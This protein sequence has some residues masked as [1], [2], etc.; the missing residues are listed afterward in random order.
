[1]SGKVLCIDDDPLV[2]RGYERHLRRRFALETVVDP[3]EALRMVREQG[4]Y[5]VVVS[6]MR[7][8]GIDGVRLLAEVRAVSPDTVRIML[9]G[10]ADQQTAVDAVNE[11][12]IFRFLT[13]PCMPDVLAGAIEAGLQ[14]Y[15]LVCA[16]KELLSK[17]LSSSVQLLTEILALLKPPAFGRLDSLR[18]IVRGMCAHLQFPNAW[19]VELAAMLS[20]IGC[21][22][23]PDGIL[24]KLAAGQAL[25]SVE[26]K[27]FRDH[28]RIGGG[29]IAKIPRLEGVARLVA[30]QFVGLEGGPPDDENVPYG[31]RV[32]AAAIEFDRLLAAGSQ[33]D[34]ALAL[35]AAGS[36]WDPQILTALGRLH[37]AEYTVR[38]VHV[39]EL[40]LGMILDENVCANSGELL[41][42]RG[43]EIV[44]WMRDRLLAYAASPHGVRQPFRVRCRTASKVSEA[45]HATTT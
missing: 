45:V 21:V 6:D 35:L 7:M 27:Q 29:L 12:H 22:A 20:Q 8:P 9:T 10:N 11:G 3:H 38:L 23:V 44:P 36:T 32:L 43:S 28:A 41:L 33:P 31:A 37:D 2:L 19:E 17:T 26:L 13:K 14:Q 18:R 42:A 24:A 30:N 1:M 39:H 25:S 5:A 4:P 15:S 34:E 40:E 16:E